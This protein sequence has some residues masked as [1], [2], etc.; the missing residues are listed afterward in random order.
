MTESVRSDLDAILRQSI[1]SDGPGMAALAGSRDGVILQKGYG[2][3]DVQ[4]RVPITPGTRFLIASVSKQFTAAAVVLLQD[5]GLISFDDYLDGWFSDLPG[6]SQRVTIRHLLT[7]TSGIPDYLDE[8]FFRRASETEPRIDDV[9]QMISEFNRL[10][11]SPG[12]K[13]SY[14]NS[15][16]VLLGRLVEKAAGVSFARFVHSSIFE[17]LAM[18]SS[19]VGCEGE[20]I[21]SQAVGYV[22]DGEE[23]SAVDYNRAVEGW[24]DGNI[25]TTVGD[26]FKWDRALYTDKLLAPSQRREV[27]APFFPPDSGQTSYGFGFLLCDRR[28]VREVWHAGG[29]RGYS[30]QVARYPDS[31]TFIALLT[32][33]NDLDLTELRGRLVHHLLGNRM[34]PVRYIKSEEVSEDTLRSVQGHYLLRDASGQ[35]QKD[36]AVHVKAC[37]KQS[38]LKLGGSWRSVKEGKIA[39]PLGENL[40]RIDNFSDIYLRFMPV[41]DR[42]SDHAQ[43]AMQVIMGGARHTFCRVSDST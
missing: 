37:P 39:R 25:I 12:D 27:F 28:G 19:R 15:G 1:D 2:L 42:F 43:D 9:M 17:P 7:H 30:A 31:E 35:L 10:D 36:S 18:D 6:W 11:F 33:R 23:H 40:Y 21:C 41:A 5:R 13:Y 8:E 29:T 32:N 3:A 34:T 24:A 26:L 4:K 22:Q 16:Y 14:S 38:V 20:L